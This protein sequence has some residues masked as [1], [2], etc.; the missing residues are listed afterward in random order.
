MVGDQSPGISPLTVLDFI[1]FDF[2]KT[3]NQNGTDLV[4]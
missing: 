3:I 4:L 2:K 1:P